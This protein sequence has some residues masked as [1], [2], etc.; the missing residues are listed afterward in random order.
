MLPF[1][2]GRCLTVPPRLPSNT[3][4]HALLCYIP[5]TVPASRPCHLFSFHTSLLLGTS[6]FTNNLRNGGSAGAKLLVCSPS[7]IPCSFGFHCPFNAVQKDHDATLILLP[8]QVTLK[9]KVHPCF[10][11]KRLL[12]PKGYFTDSS[13]IT[14]GKNTSP[15]QPITLPAVTEWPPSKR[16]MKYNLHNTG[17]CHGNTSY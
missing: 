10:L 2:L 8:L 15:K 5:V 4:I 9:Q 1:F 12:Q 17:H 3:C 13:Y 11:I 16:I 14:R 7:L 6:C